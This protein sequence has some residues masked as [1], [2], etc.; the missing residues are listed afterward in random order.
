MF[1]SSLPCHAQ[2]FSSGGILSQQNGDN[3]NTIDQTMTAFENA[4]I[5]SSSSRFALL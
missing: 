5:A 4:A 1:G 3:S 2:T